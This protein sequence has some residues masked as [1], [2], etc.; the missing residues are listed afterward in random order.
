MRPTVY[1]FDIDGTLIS[2]GGAGRRAVESA[3][4]E[5][6]GRPDACSGFSFAGMTDRAIARRALVGLGLAPDGAA[7]EAAIDAVLAT[8]LRLLEEEVRQADDYRVHA[9]IHLALHALETTAAWS[10][11]VAVGLGTGNLEA[12]A[13]IKLARV[14][15]DGRFAFGGY[16]SDA[17]DR[18]Q[19]LRVGAERGAARLGRAVDECR[20]VVI[21]DTPKDI[22]AARAISAE[23]IAVATGPY[24]V[25]ELSACGPDAT[26]EHLGVPWGIDVLLG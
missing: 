25:A 1:L 9:G 18:A 7:I 23:V 21:G 17:E 10:G 15:L 3:F 22:E 14:G 26:F 16:G 5:H 11:N 4:A 12:G 19:L 6:H 13:R 2:S 8:Y 20:V 24:S